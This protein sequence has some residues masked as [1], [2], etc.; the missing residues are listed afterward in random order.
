MTVTKTDASFRANY[1]LELR[2]TIYFPALQIAQPCLQMT[3]AS[4]LACHKGPKQLRAGKVFLNLF[5]C[6]PNS[7]K[8]SC[9]FLLRS[10]WEQQNSYMSKVGLFYCCDICFGM[11]AIG[12]YK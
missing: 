12:A 6:G 4:H 7:D 2:N 1:S 9:V 8:R 11:K 10:V 3:T 5:G